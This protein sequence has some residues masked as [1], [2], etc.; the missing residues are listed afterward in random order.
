[1]TTLTSILAATD[2]MPHSQ[3]AVQRAALL[4]REHGAR[5]QIVHVLEG[6]GSRAL[7]H[8]FGA[9]ADRA[10][11]AEQAHGTLQRMAHEIAL[12]HGVAANFSVVAG[13]PFEVLLQASRGVALVVLGRRD[14]GRLESALIGSTADRLLGACA[15]PVL[16]VKTPAV[17]PYQRLLVPID[18]TGSADAALKLAAR[19]A[20][21]ASLQLFH[22]IAS[23]RAAPLRADGA[24]DHGGDG[25]RQRAE[26]GTSARLRRRAARLGL[27]STRV[28][29]V[30]T[31][32]PAAHAALRQAADLDADLIVAG[33][34]DHPAAGRSPAGSVSRALLSNAVCDVLIV[35]RPAD[36]SRA[37]VRWLGARPIVPTARLGTTMARSAAALASIPPPPPA[38]ATALW[39]TRSAR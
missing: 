12:A 2:F 23:Q 33:R 28:S 18:F 32:G 3:H 29:F 30:A 14:R 26:D 37:N 9:P 24:T 11:A 1:M 31:H 34:R 5:L 16:V 4:A 38:I 35:P 15:R 13:D 7:R 8:W 20:R 22:A 36:A 39:P 17:A 6:E 19:L 21:D 10:R 27:D 25:T